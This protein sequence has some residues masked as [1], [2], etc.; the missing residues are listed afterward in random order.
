MAEPQRLGR[1][2]SDIVL[3]KVKNAPF[4]AGAESFLKQYHGKRLLFIASGT[5]ESELLDIVEHR[6][7]A[8]YFQGVFGAPAS[9]SDIVRKIMKDFS[10]LP[11]QALFVGDADADKSAADA[12]GIPFV[13]RM[14]PENRSMD[15]HYKIEDLSRL[16]DVITEI[17]Q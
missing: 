1:Q 11:D 17:E 6:G 14:T 2:F 3:D 15:S 4:V 5:P 13:L 9:K 12:H 8:D 7:M 16:A 10:L